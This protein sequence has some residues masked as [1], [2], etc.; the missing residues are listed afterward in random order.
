MKENTGAQAPEAFGARVVRWQRSHGRHDLPWQNT[1]DPYRIWVSEIML[2]QTQVGAVIGY[3][4]RFMERFPDVA[5]LAQ[6][7]AEEV[8][9]HWAGLGYY[10]RARNL[11]AAAAIIMQQH[12]GEFPR[13]QE[14]VQALPGI[15]RSTAAAI[16]AFAFG[17]PAA[18]LDGNVK[19]VFARH[20]GIEGYPG[21]P[22]VEK[23]FW[24]LAEKLLP[25]TGNEA[26]IQG[27]MDLGATLCT[28]TRPRCGDCPLSADCRARIDGRTAQLPT[29]KPKRENPRRATI[30]LVLMRDNA[31][32]L[33][34]RPPTGIW[35]G[36]WSLPE[37][38]DEI[39]AQR[40]A[41]ALGGDWKS[42]EA[43]S[44]IEHGFTHYHLTIQPLLLTAVK[45]KGALAASEPG[46]I[47]LPLAD[48]PTA[49]LPAPVKK[50]LTALAAGSPLFA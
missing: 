45:R 35:G 15:G 16:R 12:H 20:G 6:A 25:P 29:P 40:L 21:T 11:H 50:L 8:M 37:A 30:M 18:I 38:A 32:L 1:R 10:S 34:Q 23:V 44:V 5:A 22:R 4:A 31:V 46:S 7:P 41:Q 28:R 2:Q 47:W 19:R 3:Y 39:A 48:A 9:R 14:E 36:L 13:T 27:L 24:E 26:Y 17:A 33:E 42:R 49:A 43:L